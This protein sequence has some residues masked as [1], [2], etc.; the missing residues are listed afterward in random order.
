MTDQRPY[1][2]N[3]ENYLELWKY[4]TDD[5]AKIKD[6]MW[7]IA[8]L[9]FGGV[10]TMISFSTQYYLQLNSSTINE[11]A[12]MILLV[13]SVAFIGLCFTL[14]IIKSYG[15]HIQSGWNRANYIRK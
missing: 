1:H 13:V 10:S 7:M 6:R 4:F 11:K 8:T 12:I 9:F 14:N 5:A 3:Q 2:L 15:L